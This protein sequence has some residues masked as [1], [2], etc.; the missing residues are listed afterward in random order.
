MVKAYLMNSAQRMGGEGTV[1]RCTG[2]RELPSNTQG[3][4][5]L[6]LGRAFDNTPRILLDQK[7]HLTQGNEWAFTGT[8]ADA[9]KPL[10][11][12][13]AWTDYPGQINSESPLV[14]DLNLRVTVDGVLYIGNYLET[15]VSRHTTTVGPDEQNNVESVYLE[16][17]PAGK[18]F[19]IQ[20]RARRINMDGVTG[21]PNSAVRRQH[22][23][24]VAYNAVTTNLMGGCSIQVAPEY[25][26]S[27]DLLSGK[28]IAGWAANFNSLNEKIKVDVYDG[29]TKIVSDFIAG[30]HRPDVGNYI[31]GIKCGAANIRCD[32]YDNG[33]HGFNIPVPASLKDG[34]THRI[35]VK[36]AGTGINIGGSPKDLVPSNAT[37]VSAAS[38]LGGEVAQESIAAIFGG[39]LATGTG[40]A[41]SLPLPTTIAGST[42]RI[43]DRSGVLRLAPLFFVSPMQINYQVPPE[44]STGPATV[45]IESAN[46]DLSAANI[47]VDSVSP[48]LF[49]A[50]ANGQ[51][52]AAAVALRVKADGAQVYEPVARYDMASNRF[53]PILIDL[54]NAG[55]QVFLLLFGTGI[56][57]HGGLNSVSA[58]IGGTNCDVTYAGPQGGFVG[59]D[60]VNVLLNRSL[61]G[62][63][64]L[65]VSLKVAEKNA[66]F[67]RV[68]FR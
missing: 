14:N 23:A 5:R 17:L 42:V 22:F 31:N 67:V 54:G 65:N 49:A 58:N 20:V 10:R 24:L 53:V 33:Q 28:V 19:T 57:G 12:T 56:K 32:C 6:D 41:I 63:G 8:V 46:G 62:R 68:A 60:Q 9:T 43:R 2:Q 52:V 30:D 40:S 16:G 34:R 3:M 37:T 26:G 50:N 13:L 21:D 15:G 1:N 45:A 66:N 7:I 59:L 61:A 55:D 36:I 64:E 18:T 44:T 38:Y 48:G 51:G 25:S 29:D 4:G 11:I 27:F 39:G 47:M 35:S